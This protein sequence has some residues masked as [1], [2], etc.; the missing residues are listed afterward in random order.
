MS[1][2]RRISCHYIPLGWFV[3]SVS[4]TSMTCLY[5]NLYDLVIL[6]LHQKIE[7]SKLGRLLTL[8]LSWFSLEIVIELVIFDIKIWSQ[9]Y[10]PIGIAWNDMGVKGCVYTWQYTSIQNYLDSNFA[11]HISIFIPY[12]SLTSGRI[13]KIEH[14]G[15][16]M[17]STISFV[18]HQVIFYFA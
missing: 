14:I 15:I 7:P 16:L 12:R 5:N 11:N 18:E 1:C 3:L 6:C 4:F 17:V 13:L 8:V 9:F 10:A 2:L